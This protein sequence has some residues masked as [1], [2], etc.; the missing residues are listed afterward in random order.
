MTFLP[1]YF[2]NLPI[3]WYVTPFYMRGY[4]YLINTISILISIK[5]EIIRCSKRVYEYYLMLIIRQIFLIL[6]QAQAEGYY[7]N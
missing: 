4:R 7:L 1:F 5:I 3:N 2:Y 6:C